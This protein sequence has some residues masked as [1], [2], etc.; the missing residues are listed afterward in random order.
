MTTLK[1]LS[2]QHWVLLI[3][4]YFL[5]GFPSGLLVHAMPPLLRSSGVSLELIGFMKLL[6]LPWIFRFLWAPFVD[7]YYITSLG[8]HRSW[9]LLMQ[10]LVVV[11]VLGLMLADLSRLSTLD[12]AIIFSVIFLINL[13]CATQDIATDALAVKLLPTH[14]RGLG[15]SVQVSGYK[16]GLLFGGNAILWGLNWVG[17]HTTLMLMALTILVCLWP[18]LRFNENRMFPPEATP[19]EDAAQPA[20]SETQSF[21]WLWQQF[22]SYARGP[23]I[24]FWLFTLGVYKIGDSLGS[25]MIKPLLVDMGVSLSDI[26]NLTLTGSL[27]GIAAAVLGGTIYYRFGPKFCLL[28]FGVLQGVALG[29]YTLVSPETPFSLLAL[30][31]VFEQSADG[32]ATV[33]LFALMMEHCRKDHEGTDYSLQA[34]MQVA[35]A[36]VGGVMAGLI[37]KQ[38]G[39]TTLFTSAMIVTWICLLPVILLFRRDRFAVQAE[40]HFH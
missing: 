36:G 20:N 37:A 2:P 12:L 9:I 11:C 6:A 28:L 38:F 10:S 14:L 23:G 34:C 40:K 24:A 8:A 32:M 15:N 25:A 19:P 7:R 26:A 35:V 17:W 18:A 39:Y 3:T 33:A 27:A 21:R 31:A 5:Q 16:I 30:L 13:F 4:L 29:A 22:T 1:S